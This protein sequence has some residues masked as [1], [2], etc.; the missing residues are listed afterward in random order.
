MN[1]QEILPAF[2]QPGD[3]VALVATA[4]Y[5]D[6]FLVDKARDFLNEA[7]LVALVPDGLFERENQF[8]G[9][10]QNRANMINQALANP[11]V[12][13]IL[14]MRGGYGTVRIIDYLDADLIVDVPKWFVGYSDFT[15][16]HAYL[17]LKE[18]SSIHA[19]MPVSFESSSKDS[20]SY[21]L[22][23]LTGELNCYANIQAEGYRFGQA[24]GILRG[25]N[26]SV[27][28]SLSGS[29]LHK[30]RPGTILFLEDLDEYLYHLD[31]MMMNFKI[32][33]WFN[34]I[35]GLIVGGLSNM[36]DNTVEFGFE[37]ENPF[38]KTAKEIIKEYVE[39][40][41]FPVCFDFPAG[42]TSHNLP[43]YMNRKVSFVVRDKS[44][45]LTWTD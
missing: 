11:N 13:A 29:S 35:D 17:G 34:E 14:C 26:I 22:K 4:R 39:E 2:L 21:L 40:F 37:P 12:K 6:S 27:L 9:S 38:G 31:R 10:D 5:V 28:Y 36:K 45:D 33:G 19:A 3:V 1:Q 25:G 7:G 20:L 23:A 44:V 24:N 30:P 18:I 41:D 32:N 43:L 8:A 42:H 16:M 15:V